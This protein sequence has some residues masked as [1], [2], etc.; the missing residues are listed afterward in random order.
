MEQAGSYSRSGLERLTIQSAARHE[1]AIKSIE[2]R[3]WVGST[4]FITC[5]LSLEPISSSKDAAE[6]SKIKPE[7]VD[8]KIYVGYDFYAPAEKLKAINREKI[9]FKKQMQALD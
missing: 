7:G 4:I 8:N 9:H 1:R 3:Y 6:E 5:V 2:Y